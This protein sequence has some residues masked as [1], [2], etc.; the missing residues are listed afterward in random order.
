MT[1]YNL[2]PTF[3]DRDGYVQWR[4]AW[5]NTYRELSGAILAA[6]H[7]AKEHQRTTLFQG[8]DGLHRATKVQAEL[9]HH[10]AVG[11]KMMTLL[12]EA[13]LRR[14]RILG[15]HKEVAEQGFPLDL[16]PCKNID[17]HFNRGHNEFPFLPMW[18]LRIK[19]Q[20]Y[21]VREVDAEVPWSTRARASGS[22][23]GVL[24]FT[25]GHVRIDERGVAQ[26]VSS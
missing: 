21:Y 20:T 7:K 6:K 25:R 3:T 4:R 18:A 24:R 19:G 5:A 22:T 15:M 11:R 16:G 13:K 26:I 12:D 8:A 10:R 1:A 23:K 9:V 17:F 2:Y 14:D